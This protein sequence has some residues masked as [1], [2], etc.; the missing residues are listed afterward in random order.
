MPVLNHT[1]LR[2]SSSKWG[3]SPNF[4][5]WSVLY[6]CLQNTRP[7]TREYFLTPIHEPQTHYQVAKACIIRSIKT[8]TMY[9]IFQ[10]PGVHYVFTHKT[11]WISL[12][13]L[14]LF[15]VSMVTYYLRIMKT[16]HWL[17]MASEEF[18]KHDCRSDLSFK[19]LCD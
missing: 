18:L 1:K 13:W 12:F 16:F 11:T 9:S 14:E 8:G 15:Y 2:T 3:P 4:L 19:H 5:S 6:S 17:F 10:V 7:Q